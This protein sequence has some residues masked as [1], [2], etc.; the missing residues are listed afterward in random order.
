VTPAHVD[1]EV[2]C[3][4]I[5]G[6]AVDAFKDCDFFELWP[7]G[8]LSWLKLP[9]LFPSSSPGINTSRDLDLVDTDIEKLRERIEKYFDPKIA[10]E[11]LEDITPSL[12]TALARCSRWGSKRA[13]LCATPTGPLIPA[14]FFGIRKRNCWTESEMTSSKHFRRTPCF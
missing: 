12:I 5:E 1:V 11:K 3:V 14:G 4:W 2:T 6:G 10:N 7:G 8:D 9:E 13:T